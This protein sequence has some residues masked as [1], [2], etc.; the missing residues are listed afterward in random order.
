MYRKAPVDW[1]TKELQRSGYASNRAVGSTHLVATG[2]N[3]LRK[4]AHLYP[5]CQ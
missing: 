3:P 2:F 1:R 5:E 4:K